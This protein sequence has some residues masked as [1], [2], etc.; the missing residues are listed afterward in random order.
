MSNV[1]TSPVA[2][3]GNEKRIQFEIVK[4]GNVFMNVSQ[5]WGC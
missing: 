5:N 1:Q 2:E 3:P 4:V